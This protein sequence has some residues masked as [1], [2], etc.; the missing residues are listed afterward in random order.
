LPRHT[1]ALASSTARTLSK[2]GRTGEHH[3]HPVP[4]CQRDGCRASSAALPP[5]AWPGDRPRQRRTRSTPSAPPR[6]GGI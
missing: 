3:L 4:A 6:R 2:D 5:G 1:N